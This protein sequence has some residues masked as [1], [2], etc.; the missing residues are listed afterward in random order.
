MRFSP[1]TSTLL[2]SAATIISGCSGFVGNGFNSNGAAPYAQT[3]GNSVCPRGMQPIMAPNGLP[4]CAPI[5]APYQYGGPLA[6]RGPYGQRMA[7]GVILPAHAPYGQAVRMPAYGRM[8]AYYGVRPKQK[9]SGAY[10]TLGGVVYDAGSKNRFTEDL[11]GIQG[12]LGYNFNRYLGAEIE[13]SVGVNSKQYLGPRRRITFDRKIKH[14]EAAF[15]V[16]RLPVTKNVSV[17]L[18]GGYHNTKLALNPRST[19]LTTVNIE[20]EGFAWGPGIEWKLS[21]KNSIRA[22]YTNY[23]FTIQDLGAASVS[24]VRKF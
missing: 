5:G 15:A 11:G 6:L 7:Q 22:D 2:I 14:S 9:E 1:L 13:G 24:Y 4:A 18:R 3:R 8:P 19:R 16:A 17:M 10:A 23:D 20:D 21:P 12:R